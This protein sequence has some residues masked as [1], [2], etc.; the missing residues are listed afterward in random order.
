VRI[1]TPPARA[2]P[3]ASTNP[4][5]ASPPTVPDPRSGA[6]IAPTPARGSLAPGVHPALKQT[7]ASSPASRNGHASAARDASNSN[8]ARLEAL[9]DGASF[10]IDGVRV[11]IGRSLEPTDAID[12]DLSRL[13]R[14]VERVSR[15][16]AEI[17]QRGDDY[18]IRDLGSLNGTYIAGRGKLG[19]DQLYQLKDRDEVVLGGAKLEFRKGSRG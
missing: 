7:P 19:R 4:H 10:A 12:I 1:A 18:F 15:R 16:H 14:G 9:A 11:V 17:I 8:G 5:R 13:K 6:N 2:T 3:N